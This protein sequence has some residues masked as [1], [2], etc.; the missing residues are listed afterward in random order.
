MGTILSTKTY[1]L[2]TILLTDTFVPVPVST[3]PSLIFFCYDIGELPRL[4]SLAEHSG[5]TLAGTSPLVPVPVWY[6]P[7]HED[8]LF[9]YNSADEH[10]C[11]STRLYYAFLDLFLLRRG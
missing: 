5:P 8:L 11:T 9:T 7:V 4:P 1:Y 6:Q 10:V 2:H 3:T